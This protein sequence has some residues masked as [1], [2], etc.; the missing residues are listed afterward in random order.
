M[1]KITKNILVIGGIIFLSSF[2]TMK[3]N[4]QFELNEIKN[5]V[6]SMIYWIGED[7]DNGVLYQE[8]ADTYVYNLEGILESIEKLQDE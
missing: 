4:K 8:Y 3:I 7:V 6:E 5:T 2:T 1:K